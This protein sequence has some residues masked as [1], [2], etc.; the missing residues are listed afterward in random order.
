MGFGVVQGDKRSSA[1]SAAEVLVKIARVR[2]AG[3]SA[4]RGMGLERGSGSSSS[5][6]EPTFTRL[7][8]LY[9]CTSFLPHFSKRRFDSNDT[10]A[11]A[12][13]ALLRALSLLPKIRSNELFEC[14]YVS[15]HPFAPCLSL[16]CTTQCDFVAVSP[17]WIQVFWDTLGHSATT[18]SDEGVVS[19]LA[20]RRSTRH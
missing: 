8:S 2:C 15:F 16:N 17:I 14:E 18:R 11:F 4:T 10:E 5:L 1:V 7:N 6:C 9:A 3:E 13:G 12:N 19:S 20:L